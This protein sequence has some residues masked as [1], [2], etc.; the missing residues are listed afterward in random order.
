MSGQNL[1]II[2]HGNQRQR[3]GRKVR[4]KQVRATYSHV[5]LEVYMQVCAWEPLGKHSR[6][7]RHLVE[8]GAELGVRQCRALPKQVDEEEWDR[9][10][11][12]EAEEEGRVVT[13]SR[14]GKEVEGLER[15][16]LSVRRPHVK[17]GPPAAAPASA[18]RRVAT[19]CAMCSALRRSGTSAVAKR[20]YRLKATMKRMSSHDPALAPYSRA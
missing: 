4:A 12:G 18:V 7:A 10:D 11:L 14:V 13:A 3:I 15:E 16:E 2:T 17:K 8:L 1:V 19:W 9:G 5:Q 20:S 6:A